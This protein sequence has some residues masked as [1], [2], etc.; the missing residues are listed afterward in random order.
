[1]KLFLKVI[2]IIFLASVLDNFVDAA[3]INCSSPIHKKKLIC[4][5]K[6][7]TETKIEPRELIEKTT[8]SIIGVNGHN[9]PGS[10]VIV[11]KKDNIYSVLT[12]AH[13]VCNL[14]INLLILKTSR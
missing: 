2:F 4:K 7:K 14:K 12:T 3:E 8:V 10:G 11:R 9:Y 1:M 6:S 5:G 13:V